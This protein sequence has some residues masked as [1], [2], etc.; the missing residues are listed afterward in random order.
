MKKRRND[1]NRAS[2]LHGAPLTALMSLVALLLAITP[3]TI[4]K[5]TSQPSTPEFQLE[6]RL[7][8]DL[9][10]AR[11]YPDTSVPLSGNTTVTPH[12]PPTNTTSIN[13][14]TSTN[15]K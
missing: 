14:S 8:G 11:S 13:V 6:Q 2:A 12:T 4:A 3:T 10:K 9:I 15:F 7:N 5:N 1:T